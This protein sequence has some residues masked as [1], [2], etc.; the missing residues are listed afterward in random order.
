MEPLSNSADEPKVDENL[1]SDAS[2][3][4][5]GQNIKD[6]GKKISKRICH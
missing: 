4:V 1:D 3:G 5:G 2:Q 6:F